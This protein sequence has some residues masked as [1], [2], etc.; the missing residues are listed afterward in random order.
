MN[1]T[2]PNSSF[3]AEDETKEVAHK[4]SEIRQDANALTNEPSLEGDSVSLQEA[5]AARKQD[6][7]AKSLARVARAKEK[8]FEVKP[9]VHLKKKGDKSQQQ[10]K[11][12][13]GKKQTT[14]KKP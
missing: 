14:S 12:I 10:K 1:E 4:D 8:R 13:V 5:F 6:F 11:K 7:V 2:D 3:Q 9:R